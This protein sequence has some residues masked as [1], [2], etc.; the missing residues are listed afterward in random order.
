MRLLKDAILYVFMAK[1]TKFP[2]IR[3]KN[4]ENFQKIRPKP[5]NAIENM[6]NSPKIA[7]E[8][9]KL[10]FTKVKMINVKFVGF[11]SV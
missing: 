1:L 3:L 4:R 11:A 9:V 2:K 10:N 6:V 7:T 5:K 8:N